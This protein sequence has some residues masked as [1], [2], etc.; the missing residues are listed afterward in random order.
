M[1]KPGWKS[2]TVKQEVY[3]YFFQEWQRVKNEYRLKYGI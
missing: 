2:I 3:D 1:P